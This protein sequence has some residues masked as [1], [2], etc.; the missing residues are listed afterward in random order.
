MEAHQRQVEVRVNEK[1]SIFETTHLVKITVL[2][3]C[4]PRLLGFVSSLDETHVDSA[5]KKA[6]ASLPDLAK[7]VTELTVL[8]GVG[9]ATA[10]AVLAAYAPKVAS[11]MSNEAM[12][13]ALGNT[14]DYTLKNYL[15]FAEKLQSKAKGRRCWLQ[16]RWGVDARWWCLREVGRGVAAEV[17]V[18]GGC[19]CGGSDGGGLMDGAPLPRGRLHYYD[20]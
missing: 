15:A 10:S 6:F 4:R 7:A 3:R 17:V 8:K 1:K 11:F 9:P 14:K 16:Q 13:A 18:E 2:I 5:S 19:K 20:D 12:M